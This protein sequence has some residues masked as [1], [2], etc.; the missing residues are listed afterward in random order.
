MNVIISGTSNGIG[1]AIAEKFLKEG[2]KVYGY[3]VA[4]I[5][6]EA[7]VSKVRGEK[8]TKVQLTVAREGV[9]DYLE[10]EITRDEVTSSTVRVK[11]YDNVAVIKIS[12]FYYST[13]EEFKAAVAEVQKQGCDRI[14]FDL[15]NNLGG[16]LESIAGVLDYILPEGPIVRMID[17]NG[18]TSVINSDASCL[19][20]PMVVV[21]N[22]KT[23]SAAELFTAALRDYG[24]ATIV[25]TQTFGKGT[26]TS[27][28]K[29]SDGSVI[30]ISSELYYPPVSDNFE[31]VGLTPDVEV[32]LNDEAKNTNLYKLPLEK[33]D[34]LKKAVEII[35]EK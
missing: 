8:G 19:K 2:N 28:H 22:N 7:A 30:Y 20:M 31:G 18:K 17:A 34:Q 35:K 1:K 6:Y 9:N 27:P 3:D 13:P 26:V 4:E 14:V 16:L 11:I 15:R 12:N 29:L 23:A 10:F 21:V 33:D 32:E 25:G 24:Y 5:G